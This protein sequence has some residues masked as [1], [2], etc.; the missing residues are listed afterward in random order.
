MKCPY[1]QANEIKVINTMPHD[2]CT[3]R[4]RSCKK[5]GGIF[6]TVEE[7]HMVFLTATTVKPLKKV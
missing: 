2:S 3:I 1:C 6:K 4:V 7:V 5:C